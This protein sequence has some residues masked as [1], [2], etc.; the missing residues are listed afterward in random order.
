MLAR[1][2][3]GSRR[4]LEEWIAAGRVTVNGR[5]ARLGDSVGPG[6]R[7]RVD[8]RPVALAALVQA[9]CEVLA[10]HKPPGCVSTRRDP[11]G[12]PTVYELLPAP[13]AGRW[14]GIGRLDF[15]TGGLLLFTTDG[16]LAHR[17]MHPR[18]QVLR[19]YAVRVRG[20]LS[21][22]QMQ[23]LRAGV[24]ISDGPAG[25]ET[26]ADAGGAASNHWYRVA[27]REGRKHEVRRLMES[28]GLVVSR[29]MRVRYGPVELPRARRAGHWWLLDAATVTELRAAAGLAP[30]V[31]QRPDRRPANR[32]PRRSR[33][34][35]AGV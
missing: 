3:L 1:A 22:E 31:R 20:Q 8:G 23:A 19:E 13:A 18:Q 9:P 7:V 33:G 5:S 24:E 32:P 25:F 15:N 35:G 11:Q 14:I 12:R 21:G 6:D 16:E 29:L 27:L 28:Q 30:A 4:A 34:G 10:L 26:I 2:G 17:L